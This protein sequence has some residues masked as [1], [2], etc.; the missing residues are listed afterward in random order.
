MQTQRETRLPIAEFTLL[1]AVG[2]TVLWAGLGHLFRRRFRRGL[3]WAGLFAGTLL[4]STY[5]GAAGLFVVSV[6]NASLSAINVAVPGSI[7]LLCLVDI[8]LLDRADR[9]SEPTR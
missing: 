4:L 5:T 2:L 9:R 7:L 8:Y 1:V 3:V 6:F